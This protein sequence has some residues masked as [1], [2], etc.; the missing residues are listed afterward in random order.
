M[1][2]QH[3]FLQRLFNGVYIPRAGSDT[4]SPLVFIL[5]GGLVMGVAMPF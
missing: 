4:R 2:I 5:Y 1:A 3:P